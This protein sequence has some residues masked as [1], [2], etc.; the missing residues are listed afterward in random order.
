VKLLA[1][2]ALLVVAVPITLAARGPWKAATNP[3]RVETQAQEPDMVLRGSMARAG[4]TA[5]NL[6]VS[7]IG[8]VDVAAIMQRVRATT[9][10]SE[11]R[12]APARAAVGSAESAV[13]ALEEI[14]RRGVPE[15]LPDLEAARNA[16]AAAQSAHDALVDELVVAATQG[17]ATGVAQNLQ[18]VR[19]N[20]RHQN[21]PLEFSV[22]DRVPAQW[23]ALREA[24][25]HERVCTRLGEPTDPGIM[26][27]LATF[28]AEAPVAAARAR[29]DANQ[30]A[31]ESAW[32]AGSLFE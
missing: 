12:L 32:N 3:S 8:A 20:K 4:L 26:Q 22:V 29:L 11:N 9:V 5:S 16:L 15:R 27:R 19:A 7:G 17:L 18:Q 23:A 14:I 28:R 30:S 24:L 21:L 25:T 2:L 31:V 10:V 6:A 1:P 13:K